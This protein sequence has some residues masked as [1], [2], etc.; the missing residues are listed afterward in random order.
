MMKLVCRVCNSGAP[1]LLRQRWFGS[2]LVAPA[3]VLKSTEELPPLPKGWHDCLYNRV[4]ASGDPRRSI[5]PLLERWVQEGRPVDQSDLREMV[6]KMRSFRRNFHALEI[7]TWMSDRRY[8]CLSPGDVADRLDLIKKV[9][10]LEQAESFFGNLPKQLKVYQV[11]G[12]LLSCYVQDKCVE[13]AEAF[14]HR[15]EEANMLDS[16]A[17]NMLMKM[18]NDIGQLALVDKIFQKM[19]NKGFAP[20][21]FTYNILIEAYATGANVEGVKKVLGSM[22]HSEIAAS[23]YTYAIAAKGYVK[24]GLIDEALVL[25]EESKKLMPRRKGNDAYGFL[26]LIYSDI[27]DKS[28][29]YRVWNMYKSSD[30]VATSMYMCMMGALLKLDDVEGAEA[31]LKEWESVTSFHDFRLP[32]LLLGAYCTRGLLEKA[33]LLVNKAIESGL[34]PYANAWDRLAS[35][36]FDCGQ[37]LKAVEAMKKAL[38]EGQAPWKPNPASVMRTLEYMKEQKGVEEAE[39]IVKLLKRH[40]PLAQEIYNCLL[41]IYMWAGKSTTDLLEQMAEDGFRADEDTFKILEEK[42]EKIIPQRTRKKKKN[43]EQ[44]AIKGTETDCKSAKLA[45]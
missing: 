32:N 5:V 3:G 25:L 34:A 21:I 29:M 38:A 45:A 14:F 10:G 39:G 37:N 9:H 22:K 35:L 4:A 36:Y 28:E 44:K 11:H 24:S 26:I 1:M 6:K 16:F 13:K 33:E 19:K 31:I 17:F 41:T 15:M 43:V 20:D 2:Q 27:G 18:Y 42:S 8:F 30:K 23:C 40:G 7:S 12:A